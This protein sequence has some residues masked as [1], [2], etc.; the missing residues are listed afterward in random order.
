MKAFKSLLYLAR[1][2][3][4]PILFF[5]LIILGLSVLFFPWAIPF[6]GRKTL[7]GGWIGQIRSSRGPSGW[8]YVSLELKPSLASPWTYLFDSS[9]YNSRAGAPLRGKALLCTRPLGRMNLKIDGSTTAWSGKTLWILISPENLKSGKPRLRMDG[10]WN[11]TTLYFEEMGNNLDEALGMP[12]LG[13]NDTPDWI[14]AELNKGSE[15][16]WHARCDALE[17]DASPL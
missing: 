4:K 3:L 7:S 6:P 1:K 13:G 8:F 5:A 2:I 10:R 16:D 14:R 12:G 9:Q 17:R 11:G 15:N